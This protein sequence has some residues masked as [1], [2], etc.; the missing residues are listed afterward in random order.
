MIAD[1][2]IDVATQRLLRAACPRGR[3]SVGHLRR[4]SQPQRLLPCLRRSRRVRDKHTINFTGLLLM[5]GVGILCVP[6]APFRSLTHSL[7]SSLAHSLFW[8]AWQVC[9]V[10]RIRCSRNSA[11]ATGERTDVSTGHTL[12]MLVHRPT[13]GFFNVAVVEVGGHGVPHLT[14]AARLAPKLTPPPPPQH[15]QQPPPR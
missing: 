15:P 7:T 6:F 9:G 13:T 12:L 8:F 3:V 10:P 2:P 5:L 14:R 4:H 1:D 11:V